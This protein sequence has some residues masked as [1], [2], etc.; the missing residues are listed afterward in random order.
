MSE[1]H[2]WQDE[3]F[4]RIQA[5]RPAGSYPQYRF[6]AQQIPICCS[7]STL[8]LTRAIAPVFEKMAASH[9]TID[10][11]KVDVDEIP[12]AA[13]AYKVSGVPTFVF[14]N[15][16]TKTGQV[17]GADEKGIRANVLELEKL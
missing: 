17:V 5:G 12:E 2:E 3:D 16:S 4:R 10:F 14:I 6:C 15:K 9:P 8:T 13:S 7:A 1:W 11:C